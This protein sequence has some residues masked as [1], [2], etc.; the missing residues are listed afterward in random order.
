MSS[1]FN[2]NEILI[3][4]KNTYSSQ[5][6]NIRVQSEQKLS[7][8]KDQN[9][10]LFSS[11]LIDILK[12]NSDQIDKNLKLSI[13]LLLKRSI[14]EKIEK[15]ELDKDSCNQLIQLYIT[16]IV[17]PIISNKELE[18]LNETFVSLLN[19]TTGEILLEII[20]Y[21]NKEISSM[22]VGSVNGVISLLL[23]II[24]SSTLSKKY[25]L[26]GL[27]GI[28][29]ISSSMIQNLYNEY[30]KIN[31]EQ[32]FEDYLKFNTMFMNAFELFFQCNFKASKRLKINDEN[33][34]KIFDNIFI[35]GA[36]L[37]VNLKAKDNNRIISWTENDKI[38]K[39]INSMKI[40]IFRFLN[41]QVNDIGQIIIDKNK[42][43]MHDQ[44]IK[45][46]LSNLE[47]IIMNKYAYLIKLESED[48]DRD[49]PDYNYSLL[50]SYMFIYLKRI[51]SKDNYIIEY[52]AYFNNM[53]KNILLPLLLITNI[54]KE[55]ALDNESVNGYC[56]D[57]N[58]I[59]DSNKEK[60]IKSTVAGLIKV[61]YEKNVT[62]N[63]FI[64]KY[65][66]VLL[67]YLITKNTNLQDKTLFDE[68]DIIIILLKAYEEER[69]ICALFLALNIISN[70]SNSKNN[71]QN[72][73]Y[74]RDFFQRVFETLNKINNFPCLKHQIILF[75]QNYSLQFFEPDTNAFQSTLNYL[76]NSLFDTQYSLISNTSAEAI[77]HFFRLKNE[78]SENIKIAL[79]KSATLNIQNFENHIKN[80]QISNFFD[81]LYQILFNLENRDNEFFQKIFANLCKRV[82]VEV[83]RHYRIKFKV[84]KEK[85]KV[86]KKAT[87]K[88]NLNDYNIII[89][90]CFNIIRM[91]MDSAHFVINNIQ[92]IEE[93]LK[94]LVEYMKEPKKIDFDEDIITIIYLIIIHNKSVT[95]LAFSLIKN[96]YR[97]CEKVD[98]LLLDL[99]MLT[100]AYLAYGTEQII[101]NEEYFIGMLAL[102]NSGIKGKKYRNSALYTCILIQ[103]WVINCS[104]LPKNNIS[105][106]FDN[107]IRRITNIID[108]FNNNKSI[109]DEIYS[110][111]GYVTL[112]LC[113]LINYSQIIINLLQKTKNEN[114]LN[115][116]L[117]LIKDYN[118]A[119]F[120]YEI[121]IIIYSI[122]EIIQKGIINGNIEGLLNICIDLLKCQR[123]NA[124]FELKKNCKKDLRVN[125]VDDDDDEEEDS[126]IYDGENDTNAELSDFREI[127]DLIKNT[128]NPIKDIDE[129]KSFSELLIFLKNNKNDIYSRWENTLD[130]NRK[131]EVS[132]LF[133][134]KRINLQINK[135]NTVQVPR[136][137][138]TIKRN[139]NNNNNQ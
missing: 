139:F 128:I 131:D 27:G 20:N 63:S 138:V 92:L 118:E 103:T 61:F 117:E 15:E 98:G 30:E 87:E 107:I 13:I 64:I 110:Y 22:P 115:N 136:R 34:S 134:T 35:I 4:L 85:N 114:S 124:T 3:C 23:S 47:W 48:K 86:K 105:E 96:L 38:D 116:W 49:Y 125:F 41:L 62:S 60:K 93:S 25:F 81:V 113:G 7:E 45:I 121:K 77:D 83:E 102:F 56:I 89:N 119:G 78:D 46:I 80:T 24:L 26:N 71:F 29:T 111:L 104:N 12:S 40:K 14:K 90:K 130:Q 31:T 65:T 95:P 70:V 28:L 109:G 72:N 76:F 94:P 120:E 1:S 69:I 36:K 16:I 42:I 106:L 51:F 126:D 91:L 122:R 129:F 74:L 132:K 68:N 10:I 19:N 11:K 67:E 73:I 18:N 135:D 79:L 59:I 127:K 8:L 32:N 66:I 43:E 52:T 84:K 9:I 82:N 37:L 108:N 39:N 101:S 88:T 17:N 53:Y 137:I 6:K 54:E 99:Y 21:I 133:S 112:I 123:K 5:D 55:I 33:I 58:D 100:N 57:I 44:L 75:I 2:I 50:I 97:Y